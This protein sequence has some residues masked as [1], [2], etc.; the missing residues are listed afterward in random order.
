M[1]GLLLLSV[2]YLFGVIISALYT[3]YRDCK[4]TERRIDLR[5]PERILG[6]ARAFAV[7]MPVVNW[8]FAGIG[9]VTLM[10]GLCDLIL[11]TPKIIWNALKNIRPGIQE[12][13]KGILWFI[14]DYK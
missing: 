8:F 9:I 12:F 1:N 5:P 14:N 7:L 2:G 6:R 4:N 13:G 3:A 10:V 11:D